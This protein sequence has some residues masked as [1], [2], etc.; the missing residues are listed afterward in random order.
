MI[1]MSSAYTCTVMGSTKKQQSRY[2]V[3][4]NKMIDIRSKKGHSKFTD[5]QLHDLCVEFNSIVSR[6]ESE[7]KSLRRVIVIEQLIRGLELRTIE[8]Y[9]KLER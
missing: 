9:S 8:E 5:V 1:S 2:E 4:D 3:V 6:Y 7:S